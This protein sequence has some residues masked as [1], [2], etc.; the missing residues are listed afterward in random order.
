VITDGSAVLGLGNIGPEAAL[1][2][3]EGKCVLSKTLADVDAFPIA[4]ATQDVDEIVDT[5]VR[6]APTFGGIYLED[7]SAPRCFEIEARLRAT[8][9]IPVFHDDQHGTA[10]VVLAGLINSLKATG[11]SKEEIKIVVTGSGAAGIAIVSILQKAGFPRVT[12]VDQDGI[13]SRCR[14]DLNVAQEKI[15]ECCAISE[16]CGGLTEAVVGKDVFIGV[17][18]PNIL[19]KEMVK[20][21]NNEPIIFAL[22]N[23]VPEI[24]PDI[25][26]EAGAAIAATGRS[27]QPNQINNSLVFPGI[28]KGAI[29]A[30]VSEI[31][32][33]MKIRAAEAL[34]AIVE[35][36]T[37][38]KVIPEPFDEGIVEAISNAVMNA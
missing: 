22:A 30:G 27:D 19:T 2:V 12:I 9:D 23:P 16:I 14:T 29:D 13:V 15:L 28:F 3:M 34:A 7:I 24:D 25:A 26:R 36:P 20:T 33:D 8:L 11:R 21:M 17:S 31:T 37:A 10:I 6:I 18:A 38:D 35:N 1:P 32:D 4:L 5:I